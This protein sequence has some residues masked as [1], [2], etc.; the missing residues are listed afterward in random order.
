MIERPVYLERLASR[1]ENG[2]V[3]VISGVRRCGKSFLMSQIFQPY[4]VR[5][6]VEEERIVTIDL[7]EIANARYRNPLELDAYIR[8]RLSG[9]SMHYV[10]IDEVQMVS[11]IPNPYT[12]TGE[13]ITFVDVVLGLMKLPNVDLYLTGSN[14]KMLSSDIVTQFRGRNDEVRVAPLSYAEFSSS[15][16]GRGRHVWRDYWTYGGMP[17]VASLDGHEKKAAYLKNLF[18]ETYLKDIVERNDVRN[19]T[20][21]LDDLLDYT[22][23]AVGSLTSPDKL[24]KTFKSRRGIGIS[25]ETVERYLDYFK[26]SF[27]VNEAKRYDVKGRKYIGSPKKYYY[28]DAGLR[29]AKLNFRQ[30]EEN[31]IIENIVYNELLHR[32]YSVDVGAVTEHFKTQEGKSRRRQLE[33]DFVANRV[34]ARY[35]VQVALNI[36]SPE[37]RDQETAS[38]R[39]I[40]DSF[41]KIVVVKDDII[42]WHD[43]RGVLYVGIEEFLLNEK[44]IDL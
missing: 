15:E 43:E 19:E 24:A 42:P 12:S 3:K 39:R 11:A 1:R 28:C 26:D 14:S 6:G 13:P 38:L 8:S 31:H 16:A 23:S 41:K 25:S 35:Y 32:G 34:D 17:L 4:L 36:D 22:A 18:Q 33:V 2:L 20:S 10:F 40:G 30:L 5:D 27:L 44:A 9:K 29:N 7:D 37:K 21:V